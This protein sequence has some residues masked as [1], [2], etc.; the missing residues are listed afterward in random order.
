MDSK[1]LATEPWQLD[2]HSMQTSLEKIKDSMR[3][4]T[5]FEGKIQNTVSVVWGRQVVESVK[6]EMDRL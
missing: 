1:D 5:S 4:D 6:A 2:E 3:A